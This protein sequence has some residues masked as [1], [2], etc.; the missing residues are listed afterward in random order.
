MQSQK[1][2]NHL[3][4]FPRQIIKHHSNQVYAPTTNAKQSWSWLILW[5]PKITSRT[6]TKKR[7]PFLH[8]G[9][10]CKSEKSRDTW[11]NS[12]VWP[13]GTKW[14][15]EKAN[16]VLPGEYTGHSKHPLP[17]T[18]KMT[19]HMGITK[20]SM[21]ESYWLYTLLPKM[22]TLYT[23]SKNKTWIWLWLRSWAL[24]CKLQA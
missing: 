12:Q 5:R 17:I 16:R 21:L 7:C 14:S 10:G 11:G 15:R 13:W 18:Q 1:W 19:L 4:L 6:N 9:L 24:Y 20:W 2:Q 22:E 23:V 3:S 8:K